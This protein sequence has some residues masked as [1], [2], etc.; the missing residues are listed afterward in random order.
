MS[1]RSEARALARDGADRVIGIVRD[2]LQN[3]REHPYETYLYFK[4]MHDKGARIMRPWRRFQM[5]RWY[6]KAMASEHGRRI[7]RNGHRCEI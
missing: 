4:Y 3:R 7:E 1:L 2:E 5:R 6:A